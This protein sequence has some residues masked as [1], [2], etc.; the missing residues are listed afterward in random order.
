LT[1]DAGSAI[2]DRTGGGRSERRR[3]TGQN[4]RRRRPG[5][6]ADRGGRCPSDD[7]KEHRPVTSQT[8]FFL[9]TAGPLLDRRELSRLAATVTENWSHE[10]LLRFAQDRSPAVVRAAAGC[11]GAVGEMADCETLVRLLGHED[12]FVSAAAEDA[13][14][15]I[16]LRAGSSGAV[17]QVA[18]AMERIGRGDAALGIRVLRTVTRAEPEYA[19]AHHQL[20]LACHAREQL[21]AAERCYRRALEHNPHHFAAMCGL[22]HIAADRENLAEALDWYRRALRTNPR[23][24]EIRKIVPLLAEAVSRRDVA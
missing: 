8:S 24:A 22:G 12:E 21:E 15:S 20:A 18:V 17:E 5:L 1:R 6:V 2:V 9:A 23:L 7:G 4:P 19:E 16:W 10:D 11:L 13:L 14:W 3:G